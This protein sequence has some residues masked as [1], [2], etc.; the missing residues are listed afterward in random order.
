M[1]AIPSLHKPLVLVAED[2]SLLRILMRKSLEANGFDV[3]EAE[4]GTQAVEAMKNNK[5]SV[6]LLDVIMPIC[7]GFDACMQMRALP[8]GDQVPILMVTGLEDIDS[9]KRAYDVGATD[10]ITKPINWLVLSQR[11]HYI[12]RANRAFSEL[13]ASQNRLATAQRI[14]RLGNWMYFPDVKKIFLSE[15]AASILEL[16]LT[17]TEL[18]LVE[19][20]DHVSDSERSATLQVFTQS[21]QDTLAIDHGVLSNNQEQRFVHIQADR[22]VDAYGKHFYDGVVQ[23]I[24]I[25]KNTE[26]ELMH[27]KEEAEVASR[28]KSEFLAN[29][30]H[31][32]RTPLNSIIGFSTIIRDQM[33]GVVGNP[34]YV[35]YAQDILDAG[36]HLL[37]VINDILDLS[38][39]EAGKFELNESEFSLDKMFRSSSRI[40]GERARTSGVALVIETPGNL[41]GIFGDERAIRQ[42]LINLLSNA[43]KF[44]PE[45]GKITMRYSK[46]RNGDISIAVQDTGI[47]MKPE[48]IPKAL[49]PFVQVNNSLTRQYQGTG[50][51][52][53]LSKTLVELHGGRL[54]IE[55][56]LNQGTTVSIILPK[57]R[58][59]E[60]A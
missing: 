46:L 17:T 11:L 39:I 36:H 10:F 28:A 47:G 16:P 35:E 23:D 32:L 40:G 59:L 13:R 26:R 56:A 24:T 12:L 54:E 22:V 18:S 5:V 44:T 29:M 2:D 53:P 27:A 20:L 48:D 3:V 30:S 51:G 37:Q 45:G 57:D 8:G 60:G 41:P 55:T 19:Y 21:M 15:E 50:L 4:D 58:V 38:K 1:T 7:D 9:I 25:R 43:A 34:Q 31:E 42:V 52:L 14:A 6:V 49:E 33:F